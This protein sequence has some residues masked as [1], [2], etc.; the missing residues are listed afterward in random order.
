M[1]KKTYIVGIDDEKTQNLGN[2]FSNLAILSKH[3]IRVPYAICVTSDFVETEIEKYLKD[4]KETFHN[5]FKDI[6]STSGCYLLETYPKIENMIAGFKFSD[7]GKGKILF[8]VMNKF[9]DCGKKRFAVR[10]SASHEDGNKNSFAGIYETSLGVS[11]D[12]IVEKM[13]YVIMAYYS[14]KSIIARIRTGNYSDKIELNLIIQ[15]MVDSKISGVAFSTSS[16]SL[17]LPMV[18]WVE[19]HGELLVSGEKEANV[20]WKESRDQRNRKLLNEVI[21]VVEKCKDILACEVDTEWCFDGKT[22][23]FVQARAITDVFANNKNKESIFEVDR[24]YFDTNLEYANKLMECQKVYEGYTSKRSSKYLL[25]RK[26]QINTGKG[27]VLHFNLKGLLENRNAIEEL[28]QGDYFEKFDIDVDE[29]IRQNII[30]KSTLWD[31]LNTIFGGYDEDILHTMIIREFISGDI[32][33]ISHLM[34]NGNVYIEYS[35]DGL[36]TMNRGLANCDCIEVREDDAM[37]EDWWNDIRRF[38]KFLNNTSLMIEWVICDG[39]E[40]F[41]DYSEE[42]KTSG[43]E[44]SSTINKII[45]PGNVSGPIVYLKDT[46]ALKKMS[47]SPGVSVHDINDKLIKN[48]Q[49]NQMIKEIKK[50]AE[51]PIVFV[52]KPYAILSL[53][54]D[55]VA[56]FVFESGSLLCHLSILIREAKIPSVVCKEEF[57]D[58]AKRSREVM[59]VNGNVEIIS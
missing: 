26:Y 20:F 57:K 12:E 33:C 25:A 45:M 46:E 22:L 1:N 8:A 54:F 2:K 44:V 51:K 41:I 19:G 47:L 21:D 55:D 49:L 38:T 4:D 18:E 10:S 5:Y 29:T 40:F 58:I 50:F 36:F 3:G 16:V 48:P 53:L 35:K 39:K 42:Y 6:E 17:G 24:L 9:E 13:E 14:Y 56:G 43:M 32:G 28:C 31:Y 59:L 37:E 30:E 34:G 7:E 52:E 23:Y 11:F 27:Y 15:E